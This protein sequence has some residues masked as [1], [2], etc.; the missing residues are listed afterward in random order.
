MSKLVWPVAVILAAV[1]LAA[2]GVL[3]V[4]SLRPVARALPLPRTTVTVTATPNV[5]TRTRKVVH[6]VQAPAGV[7]CGVA[8][9]GLPYPPGSGTMSY[10]ST[11]TVTWH[12]STP[13]A[14]GTQ[15][16]LTDPAGRSNSWNLTLA[17]Q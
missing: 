6:T 11:C 2:G 12:I 5:I 13:D 7:P 1:I 10:E 4:R 14:L 9:N 15:L 16:V 8:A 17:G 3:S